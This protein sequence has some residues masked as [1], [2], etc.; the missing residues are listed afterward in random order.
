MM[1]HVKLLF[2]AQMIIH[3]ALAEHRKDSIMLAEEN[4][5]EL[6]LA[7][8]FSK[9]FRENLLTDFVHE[10]IRKRISHD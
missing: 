5:S 1:F 8:E 6:F 2:V 4:I 9:L 10:T 7:F 3:T